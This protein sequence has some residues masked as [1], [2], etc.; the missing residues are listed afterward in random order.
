M[1]ADDFEK[2]H[3]GQLYTHSTMLKL[4]KIFDTA[5]FGKNLSLICQTW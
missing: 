4:F 2:A 5:G 3:P 1:D